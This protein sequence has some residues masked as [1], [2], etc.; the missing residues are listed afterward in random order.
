MQFIGIRGV[1]FK[2]INSYLENRKQSVSFDKYNSDMRNISC[3]VSQGSILGPK[4]FILYINDT[5]NISNLVKFILF[6]DDTNIFHA[7]S[8]ISRL[9]ETIC[10]IGK[11]MRMVCS[12]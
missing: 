6:A 1:A 2:W 4:L 9:N 7:N 11:I 10:C 8:D 5:C 12:K 3:G